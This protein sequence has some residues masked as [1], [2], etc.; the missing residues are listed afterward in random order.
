MTQTQDEQNVQAP[1]ESTPDLSAV[2]VAPEA[3]ISE[4]AAEEVAAPVVEQP[5]TPEVQPASPSSVIQE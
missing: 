2:D 5:T 3:P 1:V 4:P